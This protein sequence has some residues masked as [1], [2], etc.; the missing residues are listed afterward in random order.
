MS[1]AL[2]A[3]G[4][5]SRR[6]PDARPTAA[7]RVRTQT[8]H[9]SGAG[10]DRDDVLART[11]ARALMRYDRAA[12]QQLAAPDAPGLPALQRAGQ[13]GQ[14][15]PAS[16]AHR[17]RLLHVLRRLGEEQLRILRTRQA[18][19][20]PRSVLPADAGIAPLH[21]CHHLGGQPAELGIDRPDPGR[22]LAA[23]GLVDAVVGID[24]HRL[25]GDPS[26]GDERRRSAFASFTRS[27]ADWPG[28][29]PAGSM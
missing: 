9:G 6:E 7:Y 3:H 4:E 27:D 10:P 24:H 20:Q 29:S 8:I 25:P 26:L 17:L 23:F 18:Q 21:R 5:P 16:P 15:G 12:H 2:L 1:L 14:P 28:T 13:A 11:S 19:A 22:G